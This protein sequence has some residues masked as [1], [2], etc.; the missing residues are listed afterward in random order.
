M[1]M[2]ALE[3][4]YSGVSNRRDEKACYRGRRVGRERVV[5]ADL[6]GG[7]EVALRRRLMWLK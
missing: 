1:Q 5:T 2:I 4:Q 6:R 3:N 7:W